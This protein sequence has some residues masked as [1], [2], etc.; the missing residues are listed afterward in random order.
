MKKPRTSKNNAFSPGQIIPESRGYLL[1]DPKKCT[2]CASCMFAC[3]LA[4][5]GKLN[6]A[7]SRIEILDDPLGLFPNDIQM[8]VCK[9]CGYPQCVTV[10]PTGACHID[11][12]HMNVRSVDREKCI[13]CR[14]C[15]KACPFSPSRIYFDQ[16]RKIAFKCD[17][18]QDTPYWHNKGGHVCVEICQVKAIRFSAHPPDPIGEEGYTVNLRGAGW[19]Q[20][21]M[22]TD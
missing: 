8:A 18:C 10:C 21:G 3:S 7:L 6:L 16:D 11:P 4:H 22:P 2:G 14:K 20:L 15:M 5:E 19:K 13:G 12:E 17:L 9:Q 1:V